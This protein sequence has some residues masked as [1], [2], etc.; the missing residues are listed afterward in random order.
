MSDGNVL[1]NA[2]WK[3]QTPKTQQRE[4]YREIEIVDELNMES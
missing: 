1:A 3:Y 2:A 4:R